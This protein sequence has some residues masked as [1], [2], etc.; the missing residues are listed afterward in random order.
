MKQI[1]CV[2]PITLLTN[3]LAVVYALKIHKFDHQFD[4]KSD[5]QFDHHF[6][7]QFDL[8]WE[9]M[10]GVNNPTNS[11]SCLGDPSRDTILKMIGMIG[12]SFP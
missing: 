3:M 9:I 12:S 6:D 5:H 2:V 11:L 10:P 1:S 7:Q 4:H 8:K